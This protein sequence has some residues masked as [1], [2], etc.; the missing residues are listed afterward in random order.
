MKERRGGKKKA[1]AKQKKDE[2]HLRDL[3]ARRN[4]WEKQMGK[5]AGEE[6]SPT[7]DSGATPDGGDGNGGGGGGDGGNSGGGSKGGSL[8]AATVA[9]G[10]RKKKKGACRIM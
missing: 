10:R 7:Q 2:R 4:T 5:V 8:R 1:K 6:R 9:V 3:E